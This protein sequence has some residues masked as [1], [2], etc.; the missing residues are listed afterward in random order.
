MSAI[1]HPLL[2]N[3]SRCRYN[4]SN[5]SHFVEIEARAMVFSRRYVLKFKAINADHKQAINFYYN[6]YC[7]QNKSTDKQVTQNM[8]AVLFFIQN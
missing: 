2:S 7:H 6:D 1:V 8:Q 4:I 3:P 5:Y